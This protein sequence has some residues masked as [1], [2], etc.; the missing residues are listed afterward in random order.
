MDR[1]AGGFFAL[2]GF[3][4]LCYFALSVM[5]II[6]LTRLIVLVVAVLAFSFGIATVITG[7]PWGKR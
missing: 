7:W 2:L 5:T 3:A 4:C 1:I 6:Q